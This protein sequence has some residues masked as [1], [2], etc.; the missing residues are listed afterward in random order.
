MSR[1]V[2]MTR[3]RECDF[4]ATSEK[5]SHTLGNKGGLGSRRPTPPGAEVDVESNLGWESVRI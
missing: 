4:E 5:V 3:G 2:G 1:L